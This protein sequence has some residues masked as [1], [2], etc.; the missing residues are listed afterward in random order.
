MYFKGVY[1]T[2]I[3]LLYCYF[4]LI[5]ETSKLFL[6]IVALGSKLTLGGDFRANSG[7]IP[8]FLIKFK[9]I[10]VIET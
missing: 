3:Y 1:S 2:K 7:G 10:F 8:P 4:K 5:F 9:L 6:Q